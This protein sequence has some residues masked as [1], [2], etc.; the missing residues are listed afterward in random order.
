MTENSEGCPTCGHVTRKRKD[1]PA[2][3]APW[4]HVH[5][6]HNPV[7]YGRSVANTLANYHANKEADPEWVKL[8]ARRQRLYRYGVTLEEYQAMWDAQEGKCPVCSED[9]T[10]QAHLDHDHACCPAPDGKASNKLCGKCTRG[11]LCFRCNVGLGSFK[12]DLVRLRAAMDYIK[13]WRDD[14]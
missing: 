4:C 14:C 1:G 5:R 10:E 13:R 8:R 2:K 7:Y 9:L 6:N 3:Y 12:D 11:I